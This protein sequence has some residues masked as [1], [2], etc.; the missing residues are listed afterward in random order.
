MVRLCAA[1]RVRVMSLDGL[2]PS[3]MEVRMRRVRA[4][5]L[6]LL[7]AL[8]SA[9]TVSAQTF[10]GGLRGAVREPSGVIPGVTVTLINEDTNVPRESITN[11]VGEYNFPNVRPGTYTV[12]AALT[13]FRT[14]EQSGIRI[15]TQQ[16]VTLDITLEIGQLAETITVTGEGPLIETSNA[17]TGEVLDSTALESLPAPGRNAFM[18]SVSVP[19]VVSTGDP[20]FNRQQDQTN[21]SLLSLGG[22]ARRAN[23]YLVDGVAITDMRNR[24]MLIPSIESVDEV[25]VQVHTYDAEMGRTGGG[26]FNTTLKSGTNDLHGSGFYQTRPVWGLAN[27]FFSERAGIP[28]PEDQYYRLWG[29][30]VGGPIF[31]NRT[32]FWAAIE[33]YR[34]LTTRNGEER[35]PTS[36]ER[37]GDFS[38]TFNPDGS[39]VV[40]YDPLNVVNG[41]RQPFPGNIIP[42]NRLSRVGQ[43]LANAFPTPDQDVAIA[44]GVNYQ[45][46]ASIVD[47][48]DMIS[49]KIEHKFTDNVSISGAYIYNNTDEPD[50]DYWKDTN[51]SADPNRGVLHRRPKVL[52]INSTWV[53]SNTTVVALRGGWSSFPDNCEPYAGLDEYDL[54]SLGFPSSFA[55]AV[56]FQKFPRG[57]VEGFGEFNNQNETFGDRSR[58]DLVWRGWGFNGSVS[59]FIGRHTMKVGADYRRQTMNTLDFGQSSGDFRFDRLYTV[60]N[61]LNPSGLQGSAL[62]SLLLG[63]VSPEADNQSR[64]QLST[65]LETVLDYYGVYW[66]DDFRMT[67]KLSLTYGLRYEYEAGLREKEDRFTVAFDQTAETRLSNGQTIRGGLRYAGVDGASE[68]QGD[69][70]KKK[71]SPR[72]GVAYSLNE[73][74]VIRAGYGLFWA[75]WNYQ[76]PSGINFGQIGYTQETFVNPGTLQTPALSAGG[77]GVLDNPFPNG[78]LQPRGSAD[79]LLT[80]VGQ[81]IEFVNQD[82]QSPHVQQYSVDVQRELPG[83]MA[84]S[85]SY[86][87]AR[88]DD[89]NYGGSNDAQ[90]NI[91]QLPIS[92]VQQYGAS[93]NDQVP[94]P[95]FGTEI[96]TGILSGR[97]I[98]RAQSLRPF[99][100]FDNVNARQTTGARSRYHAVITKLDKRLSNGWGGRLSYTWSR[101]DDDQFG[102]TNQYSTQH[103]DNRPL[104]AY[105]LDGEYSRGLL[106]RPHSIVLAPI[107]E[108]PFGSGKRWATTGLADRLAGGWTIALVATLESGYPRNITQ[109]ND[110][111][112]TFSG[113]QRPNWTGT[114]PVTSGST[115]DRLGHYINEAAYSAAAPFTFGTGLRTDARI[116]TPFKPNWDFSFA[117]D[118]SL[119]GT[120]RAQ[121]R[122]EILNFFN[123]AK[124][125]GGG[126]GRVGRSGFGVISSQAGFMRIW[127]ISF[128]ASF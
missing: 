81:S 83:N 91:N 23:N 128:R 8:L 65:P 22:G 38:Q 66:Q 7:L 127:Q 41:V 18:I 4:S 3:L 112:G 86:I 120:A 43:A 93:L 52:A 107:V 10:T 50:T 16:F 54:A 14:H 75:P 114:D 32:F 51:P 31:K 118:V 108:L 76:F 97:T 59:K 42:A 70:S 105:N 104:D 6:W 80:G 73:K 26:V 72:V 121:V 64:T 39:L 33:G 55:D 45:R 24:A 99:P 71:F 102:E 29:G 119:A 89:L 126:D 36:R 20:Q 100:Q 106:D 49:G 47:E 13:G 69:P 116:R 95:Y 35:F 90:I 67:D 44:G 113:V 46:T 110:N 103:Q 94:N 77:T 40:I 17:S 37:R 62:A 115:D 5:F 34:S 82:R 123:Q 111:S 124:F 25:K 79:G 61:P 96:A 78:L 87:G 28:K 84:V 21:S 85:I 48:G 63:Y 30:G 98:S 2:S 58:L 1:D 56:S 122:F 60:Q 109:N 92:V 74:T 68:S 15:S 11:E 9:T 125:N 88:G 57:W 12:R 101:L 19:T 117:K 27:N 53:A